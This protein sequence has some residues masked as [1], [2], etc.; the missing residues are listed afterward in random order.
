MKAQAG[1]IE[2]VELDKIK[3]YGAKPCRGKT[4]QNIKGTP[5]DD[6]PRKK[7][8]KYAKIKASQ[9]TCKE[10]DIPPSRRRKEITWTRKIISE[11]AGKC[12]KRGDT[13]PV[14]LHT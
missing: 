8:T 3:D 11:K 1:R 9:G 2:D 14:K 10:R 12:L 4:P 5:G 6:N 7:K 13:R